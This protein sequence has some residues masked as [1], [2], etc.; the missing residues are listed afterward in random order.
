MSTALKS[1][2]MAVKVW[3]EVALERTMCSAVRRRM[4]VK[5]T[6]SSRDS[7]TAVSGSA[8]E[9]AGA[10]AADRSVRLGTVDGSAEAPAGAGGLGA[11][12]AAGG[13]G[14]SATAGPEP[15]AATAA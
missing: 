7:V 14:A 11:C 13:A 15:L 9:A 2:S 10:D 1:T 8:E 12:P 5:G 3:A 6:T 4:L